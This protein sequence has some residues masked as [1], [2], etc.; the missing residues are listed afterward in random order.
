MS[1]EYEFHAEMQ[2]TN[3]TWRAM[4]MHAGY[5]DDLSSKTGVDWPSWHPGFPPDVSQ[6][7]YTG[8]M[9]WGNEFWLDY[10]EYVAHVRKYA[11]KGIAQAIENAIFKPIEELKP[12]SDTK[13]RL[14]IVSG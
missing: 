5:I 11:P 2:L 1:L 8:L 7:I 13:V 4:R 9:H 6:E 10:D 14:I 3:G 12:T